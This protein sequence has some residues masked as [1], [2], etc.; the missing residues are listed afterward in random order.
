[1][2]K[3]SVGLVVCE[4]GV[5]ERGNKDDVR[6]RLKTLVSGRGEIEAR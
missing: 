6:E 1:M 4:V 5:L 3:E 2:R